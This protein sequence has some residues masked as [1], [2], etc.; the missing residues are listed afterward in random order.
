MEFAPWS[1]SVD[2]SVGLSVGLLVG[3]SAGWLFSK[4]ASCL[5]VQLVKNTV[6]SFFSFKPNFSDDKFSACSLKIEVT[7]YF[8]TL[9]IAD[10]PDRNL[11]LT[12]FNC[13]R[14]NL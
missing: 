5:L 12:F 8:V 3:R 9:I 6:L 4:P 1:L 10:K 2:W 11:N 7:D 13:I 14:I